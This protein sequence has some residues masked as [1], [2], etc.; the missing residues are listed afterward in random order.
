M[1]GGLYNTLDSSHTMELTLLVSLQYP[2]AVFITLI[3]IYCHT[4]LTNDPDSM[5]S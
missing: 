2:F 4:F 5:S 3:L 1:G